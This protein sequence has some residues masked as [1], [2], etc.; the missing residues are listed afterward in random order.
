[1][2]SFTQSFI[3]YLLDPYVSAMCPVLEIQEWIISCLVGKIDIQ[4]SPCCVT[5]TFI[6]EN[7]VP[8][9]WENLNVVPV[10]NDWM[11]RWEESPKKAEKAWSETSPGQESF[12]RKGGTVSE[13]AEQPTQKMSIKCSK[14]LKTRFLVSLWRAMSMEQVWFGVC[15]SNLWVNHQSLVQGLLTIQKV[16]VISDDAKIKKL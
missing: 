2:Y 13:A 5:S 15:R 10:Y 8:A 1:M 16:T 7:T 12:L 9:P 3:K 4:Q 11:A 14:D 6:G